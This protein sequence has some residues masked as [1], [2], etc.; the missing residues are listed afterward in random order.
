MQMRKITATMGTAALLATPLL[1]ASPASATDRDFRVGGAQVDYSVERDDG[2]YEVDVD[3]DSAKP[4]SKWRITLWQ[5][6]NRYFKDVRRADGDGDVRD[7]EQTRKNTRGQDVFKV[8]IKRVGGD[9]KVRT[10]RKP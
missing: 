1:T 10:I 8:K 7:V 4:G 6:G 2:R 5:N 3:I 9:S